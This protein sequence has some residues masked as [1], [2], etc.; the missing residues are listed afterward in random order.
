[1]KIGDGFLKSDLSELRNFIDQLFQCLKFVKIADSG[2]EV[3]KLLTCD[4]HE[5]NSFEKQHQGIRIS[6]MSIAV[7]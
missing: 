4:F 6:E 1:M 2:L 3:L 7:V 5:I